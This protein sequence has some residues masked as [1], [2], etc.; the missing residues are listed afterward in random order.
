MQIV[1]WTMTRGVHGLCWARLRHIQLWPDF[2][3]IGLYPARARRGLLCHVQAHLFSQSG[4]A[5]LSQAFYQL[6]G[7]SR[8]ILENYR[9]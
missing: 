8:G 6:Y 9:H 5:R 7:L 2:G 1:G 3:N 4:W